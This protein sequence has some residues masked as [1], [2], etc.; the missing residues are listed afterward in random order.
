MSEVAFEVVIWFAKYVLTPLV[1]LLG[2]LTVNVIRCQAFRKAKTNEDEKRGERIVRIF[3]K[4]EEISATVAWI[5]GR[6]NRKE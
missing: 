6:M 5:K 4:L 2:F 1:L 3:E